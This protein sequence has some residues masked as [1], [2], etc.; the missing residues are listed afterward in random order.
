MDDA[1]FAYV[2]KLQAVADA[3]RRFITVHGPR[4]QTEAYE[5]LSEA[6]DGLDQEATTDA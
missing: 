1:E 5:R 4:E 3:A 2:R 6:L